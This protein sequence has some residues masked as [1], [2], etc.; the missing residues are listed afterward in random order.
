MSRSAQMGL[1]PK[2]RVA[3]LSSIL[4]VTSAYEDHRLGNRR[5]RESIY[6]LSL[7]LSA[8]H[9]LISVCFWQTALLLVEHIFPYQSIL[10]GYR[11]WHRPLLHSIT[12]LI[13]LFQ[14]SL[15]LINQETAQTTL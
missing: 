2:C 3:T 9:A 5:E 6:E 13:F 4:L 7:H 12:Q 8:Q 10:C 1:Q 15:P 11:N 14:Q